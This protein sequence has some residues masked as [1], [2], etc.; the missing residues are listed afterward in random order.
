M[1]GVYDAGDGD[2]KEAFLKR[3]LTPKVIA[4]LLNVV[5]RSYEFWQLLISILKPFRF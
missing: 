1:K 2:L 5:G 4:A 3:L